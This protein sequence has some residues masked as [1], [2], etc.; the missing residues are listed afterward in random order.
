MNDKNMNMN[1]EKKPKDFFEIKKR[2]S[3]V[4]R[5]ILSGIIVFIAIIYIL[6]IN[7]SILSSPDGAGMDPSSVFIATAIASGLATLIMGLVAKFP[8]SLSA[9]MGTNTFFSFTVCKVL[10]YT[11]EEGLTITLISG[12]IFFLI[13]ITSIRKKIM[14][15]I[16]ADLRNAI[17]V[18]LG[19]FIA[20]VG[21]K[22]SG[23]IVADDATLIKLGDFTEPTVLLALFGIVLVFILLNI[24]GK[25]Q[26]FAIA[27]ALGVTAI[28]G[29]IL[30]FCGIEGM[31]RFD[32]GEYSI[33]AVSKTF[34]QAFLH[35]DVLTKPETYAIIFSFIFI[36]LFNAT[37]T[38]LAVGTGAGIID[39]NGNLIGGRKAM[40]ADA[41][42]TVISSIL[43][44]SPVTSF[45]ESN[46]AVE[47]GA[48]T[49]LSSTVTGI[50][51]LLSI[52]MYP[53][54][55]V[56]SSSSITALALVAVGAMMFSNLK[57]INWNDKIVVYT[58][59]IMI[60]LMVLCYSIIDGLGLS[61][62]LYCIMMLVSRRGKEVNK[63]IY[64]IAGFFVLSYIINA[65]L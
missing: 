47:S 38:L 31:P 26:T 1:T 64:I 65:I 54:F 22:G 23:I 53:V 8:V 61:I 59:F 46:I 49:G 37:G 50:L 35:F 3:T 15:G 6:P 45:V 13:T 27:I 32:N 29:L 4:G 28:V 48:K 20:F 39:E 56:F 12:I 41:S 25:I 40:L 55:S 63:I 19:A 43:G 60:I 24:K 52:F 34:G 58:T 18:G 57:N 30:G 42:G 2:N 9:G 36:N 44:S 5:E 17:I 14:D 62:I 10:G 16:P 21:L 51:F 11:W 33:T 7:V